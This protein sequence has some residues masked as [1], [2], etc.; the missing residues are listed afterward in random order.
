MSTIKKIGNSLLI[1][2]GVFL[3][4]SGVLSAKIHD[5]RFQT[6]LGD[7]F[8]RY[9]S[10]KLKTEISV[11]EVNFELFHH[12]VLHDV[13]V[14]D[15]NR[16][17]LLFAKS[18]DLSLGLFDLFRKK[19][20]IKRITL[21]QSQ[22]YLHKPMNSDDF[23]F[24]FIVDAF[25][26]TTSKSD[27]TPSDTSSLTQLDLNALAINQI[28]FVLLDEPNSVKLNFDI[29][30]TNVDV[31]KLD[32]NKS[33]IRLREVV[34]TNADLKIAKLQRP[35]VPDEPS[36]GP[37]TA[38]VHINTKP[39][40]LYVSSLR[41]VNSQFQFD[42]YNEP[43]T[44]DQFDSFH[45][46]YRELNM[47]FTDGSMV[48]DTINA[49]ISNISFRE[50][51]GFELNHMEAVARITPS[52]SSASKLKIVTSNSSLSNYFS[53]SYVNFH[54][55]L[56]Y[57]SDVVMKAVL[58][59]SQVAMNDLAFFIPQLKSLSQRILTTGTFTGSLDNLKG[60]DL[61]L[62]AG[63]ITRF[64]GNI[65]V[66]GLPNAN[67]SY[68]E[69]KVDQLV[70]D[71]GD[72][73]QIAP[74]I[75]L[76]N[77]FTRL[78]VINFNGSFTGFVRDFVA[79]G[80]MNT[81]LGT[82][83]S[84]L[85]MKLN[86]NYTNATYSGNLAMA[87]FNIGRYSGADSLFGTISFDVNVEGRGLKIEDLD[88]RIKGIVSQFQF[89]DYNY[90]NL[91]VDGLF[92]KKL[93][94]GTLKV[95]D[96]NIALD[97]VG[98]VDLNGELPVYNFRANIENANLSKLQFTGKEYVLSTQLDMNMTGDN[99]DNLIGYAQAMNTTFTKEKEKLFID[100]VLLNIN[101]SAGVKHFLLASAPVKAYF[102]G[103][104]ALTKLPGSFLSVLDHYFSSLPVVNDPNK[105]VL[106][107]F[108]F[109]IALQDVSGVL[110]FFLPDWSGISQSTFHGHFNS[111]NNN[112]AFTGI[113]PSIKYRSISLDT[114][115]VATG[116]F[117]DQLHF[118]ASSSDMLIGDSGIVVGPSFKA[119]VGNDSAHINIYGSN[120]KKN[121]SLNLNAFITGDTAGLV[122]HVLPSD[123]V[124]NGEY[125]KVS[126]ENLITYSN[127]RLIFHNF[128]LSHAEQSLSISN[129]NL[130]PRA[131]NLHF[132]FNM[133]P[134]GNLYQFA[135]IGAFN[136]GGRL[137]G[138][139]EVLNV[140][141]SPR[142]QANAAIDSLTVNSR[143]IQKAEINM[144]YVPESDQVFA[145]VLITDSKY[146]IRAEGAYFPRRETDQLNFNFDVRNFDVS[147]FE[148]L[149]PGYFSGTE[150]S[151]NGKLHLSGN[152]S[153]P[154]LTGEMTLPFVSTRVDYLQTTYKTYNEK[155]T[156][157]EDNI[158]IGKMKMYDENND[159]ANATGQISHQHLDH[160]NFNLTVITD[161]F[162]GLKTTE[163]DNTLFYGVAEVRGIVQFLGPLEN[164]EIRA[165]LSSRHGTQISIPINTGTVVA[166]RSFIRLVKRGND[167]L[168]YAFSSYE[169][170]KG[171]RLNLDLDITPDA[172]V[173]L[174]FDQKAGDIITGTGSGNIRME[175][176]TKGEFNMYGI[177]TIDEGHYLFTLQNF[178]NKYFTIDRGGTVSWTGDP[179]G[180]QIDIDAIYSTKASVYDLVVGSGIT[181]TSDQE[182]KDL[183]RRIPVEVALK[184]R[185]SLLLPD[186]IF[187][188]RLPDETT[189]SSVAY[190]QVEKVKQDE[191][192][193]NK[194]VFGLLIL[195]RFIPLSSGSGG[196]SL[197]SDVNNSVS[198]FLLNQLSYWTSQIRSDID[199]NFNY[200][201]YE[202]SLNATNPNDITKRNELEVA[203][204]KRFFN[205]RLALEAG[206]NFDFASTNGNPTSTPTNS[207]TN[208]AGDFS[209]DY[210]ITPDGR[211]SGKAFSKSQYDVV[212]ERYKTKNG[213]ALSYKR[214]FTKLK[215]LFMK[216]PEKQKRKEERR[217]L[218]EQEQNQDIENPPSTS[219]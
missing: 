158:D 4:L 147:F 138:S 188:I 122:M 120:T 186:V 52:L 176:D 161:R 202:S 53:M 198:Q 184:L 123:F 162:E 217:R 38:V 136:I 208:V 167:S 1:V 40:K 79:Y 183:Q 27:L 114:M 18:L 102:N 191:G 177:Y 56:N 9:F 31:K 20:L 218:K 94:A 199:V 203:L 126:Q 146:D 170:I 77:E 111:L 34:F 137:S 76:R 33:L 143:N 80:E 44:K 89:H 119:D 169:M 57:N 25:S 81:Q 106:Q 39:L 187:D 155:V 172:A 45:Q 171:L 165:S 19:Y 103:N 132:D 10:K 207:S 182:I 61:T 201:S 46:L 116:N 212:D 163:K 204:T 71:A 14:K 93:F 92:S 139:M 156:F 101:E 86:E 152:P 128:I 135:E 37:D 159:I 144:N 192:E 113:I 21:T 213:I 110:H 134:L 193:L 140:F 99:I 98:S 12:L 51:S 210:K 112:I 214:E 91:S 151:S 145:Q 28:H 154:V 148:T 168:K 36:T 178:F 206:G 133:L 49:K 55:F 3:I 219:K 47:E 100:T 26:D 85:N 68:I 205:D 117:N 121:I 7:Q 74:T 54:A 125:W 8:V 22:V 69:F 96:N 41:F 95:N 194:Q 75:K 82:I 108:D 6:Y 24:Q 87:V 195:N 124:L 215:E 63:R 173:K 105:V 90:Q 67:E 209:V 131:T 5:P 185:G 73:H 17:T 197:G 115:T 23:N 216:D 88:T 62:Q 42:D 196:Q 83:K 179:Y 15:R 35:I 150:G 142:L 107:D 200:Q 64:N 65:E 97:F 180:A 141:H 109:E 84:D 175:I 30:Q 129:V 2:L 118:T 50:K 153:S 70:T 13:V 29:P 72:V 211:L 32:L 66:K 78:G 43:L 160:F 59:R 16:D 181:F 58:Q 60:K 48:M 166:D 11:G 104:F 190:Q 130:R 164:M 174:I 189:L 149:L 127:E 157:N